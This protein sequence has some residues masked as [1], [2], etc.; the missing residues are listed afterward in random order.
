MTNG[1]LVS[2]GAQPTSATAAARLADAVATRRPCVPVREVCD[3]AD[4]VAWAYAVQRRFVATAWPGETVSGR[5]IGLT[6]PAVQAQLGVDQPDFGTLFA[7]MALPS[8]AVVTEEFLQPRVEG[9]IAFLLG[10]DLGADGGEPTLDDVRAA[11]TGAC[12]A[13]EICDSRIEGW[14]IRLV[15]TVADNASAGGYVLAPT[16][17]PLADVEPREATMTMTVT[18]HEPITGEGLA[19]LGDPLEAVLWLAR[20]CA[21]LGDPLR[22]GEVVLSGALAPMA[23]LA[24]GT[25]VRVEVSGLGSVEVARAD[26]AGS[27]GEGDPS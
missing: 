3:V 23:P 15:D 17:V 9:E 19:C 13:I 1:S 7:S 5:K 10:S 18:G 14:D 12:G 16:W 25:R 11:V 27:A 21:R 20:T 6:S 2:D 26:D 4:E 8:G 22:A 24:P